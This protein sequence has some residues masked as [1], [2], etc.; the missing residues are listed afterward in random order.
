MIKP[1]KLHDYVKTYKNELSTLVQKIPEETRMLLPEHLVTNQ[2]IQVYVTKETGIGIDYLGINPRLNIRFKKSDRCIGD[3]VFPPT[4]PS[5][6]CSFGALKFK[7]LAK[8]H[9]T[10]MPLLSV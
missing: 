1:K 2:E 6:P 5:V 7:P 9:L 10:S 3:L 8:H 4:D